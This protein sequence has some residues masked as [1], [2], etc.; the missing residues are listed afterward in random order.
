MA[1]W[2]PEEKRKRIA[3]S[4]ASSCTAA[5]SESPLE[6]YER[7]LH[8]FKEIDKQGHMVSDESN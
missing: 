7:L 3:W 6:I 5:T 8:K 4:V 1:D 2:T